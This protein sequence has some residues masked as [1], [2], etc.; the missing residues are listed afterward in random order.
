MISSIVDGN[1]FLVYT[2]NDVNEK[3]AKV[4]AIEG[5][6]RID[7]NS[8]DLE[9]IKWDGTKWIKGETDLEAWQKK[10]ARSDGPLPRWGE[11]LI[12]LTDGAISPQ[13]QKLADDK[14]ALRA[15]RP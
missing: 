6:S 8:P 4:L 1:G 10:M 3:F 11:D 12:N 2:G 5:H 7:V 14:K 13:A 15:T 9:K